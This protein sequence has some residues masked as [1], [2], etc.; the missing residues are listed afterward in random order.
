MHLGCGDEDVDEYFEARNCVARG[1]M[2]PAMVGSRMMRECAGWTPMPFV[3][4]TVV[5]YN[6]LRFPTPREPTARAAKGCPP[7]FT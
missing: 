7:P 2:N 1:E 3:A 6:V 5:S 4:V